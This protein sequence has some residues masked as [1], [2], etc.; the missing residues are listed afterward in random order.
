[1]D[2]ELYEIIC[3][4]KEIPVE[5][6]PN[7]KIKYLFNLENEKLEGIQKCWYEDGKLH[8]KLNYIKN[9]QHG[10]QK[11]WHKNRQLHEKF[12][13][14]NGILKGTQQIWYDSGKL[15]LFMY[16]K[17]NTNQRYNVPEGCHKAWRENGKL[18]YEYNYKNGQFHGF[19]K[20]WD[21]DGKLKSCYFKNGEFEYGDFILVH[22]FGNPF[23][24]PF[25]ENPLNKKYI[26][27]L[28]KL[29]IKFSSFYNK[30][31]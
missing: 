17:E 2:I 9:K 19:Q 12:N 23:A 8:H 26:T 22:R 30:I 5:W 10:V 1:M 3:K 28:P 20:I 16:F 15:K 6:W 31:Y 4:L 18:E 13:Y 14:I 29:P 24:N 27:K 11:S 25:E 21:I 7:G